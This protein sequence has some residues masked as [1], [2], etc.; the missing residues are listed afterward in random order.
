MLL[1]NDVKEELSSK[2]NVFN[3]ESLKRLMIAAS[4]GEDLPDAIY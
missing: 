4:K 3:H 1:P 2:M